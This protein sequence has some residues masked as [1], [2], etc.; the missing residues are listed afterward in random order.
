M[1]DDYFLDTLNQIAP[2]LHSHRH[3]TF[4]IHMDADLWARSDFTLLCQDI[5]LL[6]AWNV[7][8]IIVVGNTL[9]QPEAQKGIDADALTQHTQAANAKI[10]QLEAVLSSGQLNRPSNISRVNISTGNVLQAQSM[11]IINGA[12]YQMMGKLTKVNAAQ[13]AHWQ[14]NGSIVVLSA[15]GYSVSGKV[16]A[17]DS[18][19]LASHLAKFS[20]AE[21]LIYLND[22][23]LHDALIEPAEGQ[24]MAFSELSLANYQ[25]LAGFLRAGPEARGLRQHLLYDK[26]ETLKRIH[27]IQAEPGALIKELYTADGYGYMIAADTYDIMR[28]A[29]LHDIPGILALIKPL[30]AQGVLVKRPRDQ[31]EREYEHFTVLIRD[32]VIIGCASLYPYGDQAELACFVIDSAYQG[33]G[34]AKAM[35]SEIEQQA[36]QQDIAEIFVLTTQT[37][38]WFRERG[39]VEAD[40]D[41]LPDKKQAFYNWQRQ[42]KVLKLRIPEQPSK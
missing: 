40:I 2:Y 12:D 6:N 3:K 36:R 33:R 37:S 23:Y 42:S 34:M 19:A 14:A 9:H 15:K 38:D 4:V 10:E 27:F 1:T 5:A 28:R 7:K 18:L 21:K 30:E 41:A 24:W 32:N 16:Y 22:A 39:F 11:G 26:S 17:L 31:L 29:R 8:L 20:E 13:I 35:L 25:A